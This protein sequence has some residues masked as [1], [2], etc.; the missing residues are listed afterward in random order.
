M[1]QTINLSNVVIDILMYE[2]HLESIE[3][4]SISFYPVIREKDEGI[5]VKRQDM[6]LFAYHIF[7]FSLTLIHFHCFHLCNHVKIQY[8]E[9][10]CL[11]NC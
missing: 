8:T 6:G 4:L 9:W 11:D 3:Y 1:L 10:H 5:N 7:M 2:G